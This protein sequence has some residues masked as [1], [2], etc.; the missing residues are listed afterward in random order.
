MLF[1]TIPDTVIVYELFFY[2]NTFFQKK[3]P[4]FKKRSYFKTEY[5]FSERKWHFF[6]LVLVQD[7]ISKTVK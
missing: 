5:V 1:L 2:F 4:N 6:E 7:I 3:L